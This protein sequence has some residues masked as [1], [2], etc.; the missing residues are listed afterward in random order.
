MRV[1]GLL[2]S[3]T[4]TVRPV[5]PYQDTG[6]DSSIALGHRGRL[7]GLGAT[8]WNE[9]VLSNYLPILRASELKQLRKTSPSCAV[10]KYHATVGVTPWR[11]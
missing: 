5:R 6:G 7:T 3:R 2:T 8:L 10:E 9:S 1:P 11:V 4:T